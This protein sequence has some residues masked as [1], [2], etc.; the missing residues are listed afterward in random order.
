MTR[1][2]FYETVDT[3]GELRTVAEGYGLSNLD[4]VYD[5]DQLADYI[6]NYSNDNRTLEEW[7]NFAAWVGE[8]DSSGEWFIRIYVDTF[9]VATGRQFTSYK[10]SVY[11]SMCDFDYFDD[12]DDEEPFD[13][14]EGRGSAFSGNFPVEYFVGSIDY[15]EAELVVSDED[16]DLIFICPRGGAKEC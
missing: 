2:D 11:D 1:N 3:W 15:S 8:I 9:E 5:H 4:D 10:D 16:D 13:E 7:V 12:D 14:E 6:Y